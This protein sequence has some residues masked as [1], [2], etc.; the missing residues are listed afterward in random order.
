M[1]E[2]PPVSHRPSDRGLRQVT[3]FAARHAGKVMLAGT[4]L[5]LLCWAYASQLRIEGSFAALLPT[6][7]PTAQ[8]FNEALDRRS[9]GNA[10]L[11]VMASSPSEENNRAFVDALTD[12]LS[13]LPSSQ[14]HAVEK[15]PGE[16]R[17]FFQKWRWLFASRQDLALLQ[18]KIEREKSKR[19]PGYLDLE[20]SCEDT[21]KV[22][23][24]EDERDLIALTQPN[25]E[26]KK[27]SGKP[28]KKDE[29]SADGSSDGQDPEETNEPTAEKEESELAR[30]QRE[31]KPRLRSLDRYPT[32]YFQRDD[33]T[34]FSIMI[35]AS[36]AGMGE[37]SSDKLFRSVKDTVK[38][39]D[40]KARGIKVG[41]AGDIP[42]A[43]EQ[44]DALVSDMAVISIVSVGLILAAIVLFFRSFTYVF[45][46]GFCVTVGT[47]LAFATAMAVYGRL[48]TAT[49]FLG[50][51]IVGN[52][53][54]YGIVYLA[55]YR[56]LRSGGI[57][58]EDALVHAAQSSRKG[59]WLAAVAAGGAYGAL[60]LTSFRGFSEFGLIGGVGMVFC[61][62]ATFLLLPA[63][64]TWMERLRGITDKDVRPTLPIPLGFV[65][66][67]AH[68]R[69]GLV[70]ALSFVVTAVAVY[71]LKDYL[72]DPWEY[73]FSKLGSSSSKKK[74]AGQWSKKANKVFRSRG[75][76]MLL[77]ADDMNQVS[78]LKKSLRAQDKRVSDGKYIE[79]I[80]TIFD[81]LGGS[82]EIVKEKLALL[83][84]IRQEI[85]AVLPRLSPS[86]RKIAEEWRPPEY[87]RALTPDD[88][89][90]L[91]RSQ[92]T[93]KDG[94]VGTPM[95]VY[96]AR[97]LSQSDGHN[98]LR[99]AEIFESV[100]TPEGKVPPNASRSTVFAAMVRAMERDGPVAT[101]FAFLT[102]VVVTAVVTHR[103]VTTLAILGS[104]LC[105]ILLTVG[106]A[107]WLDVRLNFLNFVA[108]PLTCGIGVEY[109]INLYERIRSTGSVSEGVA[110][111]G[112]PVALCSLTTIL[113]YGALTL[114]DNM[115]LQSFGL[116]AIAGEFACIMT[117]LFVLPSAL[118][119]MQPKNR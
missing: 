92:F 65:S 27:S 97:G 8:R 18:C 94:R 45:L 38:E 31:L 28:D 52:G 16:A 12:K 70:L 108:L 42:N 30:F 2:L 77:L 91:V 96:L 104:L 71:P 74:G 84:S 47:G 24:S 87:L 86:D 57:D 76:P 72:A 93:E 66:R 14:V 48:N 73:N 17:E 100:K 7:S 41:Y 50:A 69:G 61:W 99:I 10:T 34:L 11:I 102:V 103:L 101:L 105:A 89:P 3:L 53:I 23:W 22:P 36:S 111:I 5:A 58:R 63:Q 107:A 85:D 112:A 117:A 9:G 1:P 44:R 29:P 20:D 75:S 59:T 106:G 55:R 116:Y 110:S 13:K 26:K 83:G 46:I 98:L 32:G 64:I 109:A 119:R 33:G 81:R 114:A 80:E 113:G 43:I 6:D 51:I 37:F 39:L 49:S 4:I 90:E 21:V 40:P 79:R 115:A 54:N 82:P 56:E 19:K 67:I 68:R 95:Y 118:A 88:L 60:L 78:A 35:R 62:L 25:D 15:G